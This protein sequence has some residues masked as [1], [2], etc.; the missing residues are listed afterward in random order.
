MLKKCLLK[1]TIN[2]INYILLKY[3]LIIITFSLIFIYKLQLEQIWHLHLICTQIIK[4]E[5]LISQKSKVIGN[6]LFRG[7]AFNGVIYR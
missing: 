5:K 7:S 1:F 3:T 2:F 4:N 6:A